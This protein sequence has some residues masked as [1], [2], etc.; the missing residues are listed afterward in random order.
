MPSDKDRGRF[1]ARLRALH[2]AAGEPKLAGLASR[3]SPRS[4]V[5]PQLI[6][7]WMT[8]NVPHEFKVLQ[9]VLEE[10]IERAEQ[11]GKPEPES[12]MYSMGR[13]LA[14]WETA[15]P[16]RQSASIADA[17]DVHERSETRRLDVTV[18]GAIPRLVHGFQR[19]DVA[20]RLS[21][22]SGDDPTSVLTST[23]REYVISG[24]GGVGK[25]QLAVAYA[26]D[27]IE[28]RLVSLLIWTSA[29]DRAQIVASF[30]RAA[31][32]LSLPGA[33]SGDD[34][35]GAAQAL[36][37]HLET[38]GSSWI[39]FL[40]DL[41]DP[42][43]MS[44]LWPPKTSSG[45]TVVTTRRG[46]ASLIAGRAV[47]KLGVF[48]DIEAGRF[49]SATLL[50]SLADDTAGIAEDLQYL[51]LAL[52]HAVAYMTDVGV[53]CGEYRT[54]FKKEKVQ[55]KRLFPDRKAI[56]DDASETVA[57]TWNLSIR[58]ADMLQPK[59]MASRAL[60]LASL[61]D[62]AGVPHA[63]LSSPAAL[64][65][66]ADGEVD[67][68]DQRA[69]MR[70]EQNDAR[71]AVANL[72][73]FSLAAVD[74]T[75]QVH[76]LVQRSVREQLSNERLTKVA[77][78]AADSLLECWT[79]PRG[80]LANLALLRTNALVLRRHGV[81]L[82]SA[83][84]RVH[85]VFYRAAKSLGDAGSL[86]EA[87]AAWSDIHARSVTALGPTHEEALGARARI[88]ELHGRMGD[89]DGAVA[90]F[91]QLLP[92]VLSVLGPDHTEALTIRA[93]LANLRGDLGDAAGAAIELEEVLIDHVRVLGRNH[94]ETITTRSNLA[95][96]RRAAGNVEGAASA[97]DELLAD[98]DPER[99]N[100]ETVLAVLNNLAYCRGEAGDAV[101]AVAAYQDLV[102]RVLKVF[103]SD[104]ART[105]AVRNNLALWR[106]RSGDVEGAARAFDAL[107]QDSLRVLGAD[108]PETLMAR[109]NA[110]SLKGEEGNPS[111]AVQILEALLR[112]ADRTLSGAHPTVLVV[113]NKLATCRYLAGDGARA[114]GEL[115]QLVNDMLSVYGP[116]HPQ[117][118]AAQKKL[119]TWRG[120]SSVGMGGGT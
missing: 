16:K 94:P 89:L 5:T 21:R 99:E 7:A 72:A 34:L 10:L 88:A 84:N 119:R 20:T 52:G 1:M 96:W 93:E 31:T 81:T 95:G 75:I 90:A 106:G 87:I 33:L 117:T 57:T 86:K 69:A 48:T 109:G 27:L 45:R 58:R 65:Y 30:A 23:P 42:A 8:K 56:F 55:L 73:R 9:P 112:D 97:Y 12:G 115:E 19:R 74:G 64:G 43:A 107:V 51:P 37:S 85:P 38:T 66:L 14:W 77:R 35:E 15:R 26:H 61:L 25:T 80:P 36:L 22:S 32:A 78:A 101:G 39:V 63:A 71:T 98:I 17:A 50:P 83:E 76:A 29:T 24:L 47:I 41:A 68:S 4:K 59:G 104:D 79:A 105:L 114:L 54:L 46:D 118:I 13:W 100:E 3:V 18:I 60:E 2:V 102:Q 110:A 67:Q 82:A 113:R 120:S 92:T 11:R 108:H 53:A 91:G 111:G 49:L 40:D 6:S 28:D 103:G 70:I 44:A 116:E 62:P